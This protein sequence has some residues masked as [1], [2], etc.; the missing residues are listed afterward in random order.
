MDSLELGLEEEG[1][2][3]EDEDLGV[4]YESRFGGGGAYGGG[5]GGGGEF[6]KKELFVPFFFCFVRRVRGAIT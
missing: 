3:D 1:E 2:R 4:V 5:G 6:I